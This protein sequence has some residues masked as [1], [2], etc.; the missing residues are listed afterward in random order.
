MPA[1]LL[2]RPSKKE[3]ASKWLEF[4]GSMAYIPSDRRDMPVEMRPGQTEIRAAIDSTPFGS[5]KCYAPVG[6]DGNVVDSA[7]GRAIRF[8]RG[9]IRLIGID[10]GPF[11]GNLGAR[12]RRTKKNAQRHRTKIK[13]HSPSLFCRQL[14]LFPRVID[15]TGR[16]LAA[17]CLGRSRARCSSQAPEIVDAGFE[18]FDSNRLCLRR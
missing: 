4:W 17:H 7:A 14:A 9:E 11:D 8:T 2:I 10:V 3:V 18:T 5:G 6:T 16:S 15:R 1:I 12:A 13:L